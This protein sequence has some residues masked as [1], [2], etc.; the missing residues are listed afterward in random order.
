MLYSTA[1]RF[2]WLRFET[3]RVLV[4]RETQ[5]LY[6]SS[7]L[8]CNSRGLFAAALCRIY[9]MCMSISRTAATL[10]LKS[11][12]SRQKAMNTPVPVHISGQDEQLIYRAVDT[13]LL[14]ETKL[15]STYI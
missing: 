13:R 2:H 11:W 1:E 4:P 15:P 7:P 8:S 3:G 12:L 6:T 5:P 14:E 10:D 9:S